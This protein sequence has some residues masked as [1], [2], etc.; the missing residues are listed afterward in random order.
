MLDGKPPT[1]FFRFEE[2]VSLTLYHLDAYDE[3]GL[4]QI[5]LPTEV[6][7]D[8]GTYLFV[9]LL[10]SLV[11]SLVDPARIDFERGGIHV[12]KMRGKEFWNLFVRHLPRWGNGNDAGDSSD[13]L[14]ELVWSIDDQSA[15]SGTNFRYDAFSLER[16]FYVFD[17][18][19]F[20]R[21]SVLSFQRY[22]TVANDDQVF[23][24]PV[25]ISAIF[26]E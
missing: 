16:P 22:L 11:E 2:Y 9:D 17:Q 19:V 7:Y 18:L 20:E 13:D 12:A 15:L 5:H 23:H 6:L 8:E 25:G 1:P 10:R 3:F 21:L 4:I 24:P 14:G 26:S